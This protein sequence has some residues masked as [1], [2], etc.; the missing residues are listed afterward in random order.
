MYCNATD[1]VERQSAQCV[2]Y[3]T[4]YHMLF[5]IAPI[6]PHLAEEAFSASPFDG[7]DMFSTKHLAIC[8]TVF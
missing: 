6:L 4:L 1:E 7:I 5:S 8:P 2:I 3:Y